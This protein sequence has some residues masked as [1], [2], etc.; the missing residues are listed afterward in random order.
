MEVKILGFRNFDFTNDKGERIQ[1]VSVF[2]CY[3]EDGVTGEMATKITISSLELWQQLKDAVGG[4]SFL[5]GSSVLIHFSN[6]G[7]L[8]KVSPVA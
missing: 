7:K 8:V 1:G 6:K 4:A 3:P 5:P 2:V